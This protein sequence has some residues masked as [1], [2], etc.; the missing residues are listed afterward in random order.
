MNLFLARFR[1]IV[2]RCGCYLVDVA[3]ISCLHAVLFAAVSCVACGAGGGRSIGVKL[4][5]IEVNT[6]MKSRVEIHSTLKKPAVTITKRR[7][8]DVHKHTHKVDPNNQRH[9]DG[10]AYPPS[11]GRCRSLDVLT[12]QQTTVFAS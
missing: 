12:N 7:R 5:P 9:T 4:P 2:Y 11:L 1:T 8:G 3:R 10:L 6:G